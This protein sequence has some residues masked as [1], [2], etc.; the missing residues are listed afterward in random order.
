MRKFILA[1]VGLGLAVSAVPASAHGWQG[2]NERQARIDSRID[3]GVRNG[4]L[5]RPE[6]LRLRAEFNTVARLERRYRVGG[7]SLA[8]RRDLDRRF[9][10]LSARVRY[11]RHDRQ[12]RRFR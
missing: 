4:S 2:I 12:D 3:Q 1:A 10:A 6:A 5:T 11:D 8:E 7:L 9:D